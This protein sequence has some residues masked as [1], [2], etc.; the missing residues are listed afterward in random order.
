MSI[1][2]INRL[3]IYDGFDAQTEITPHSGLY[4]KYAKGIYEFSSGNIHDYL[5]QGQALSL[6][7]IGTPSPRFSGFKAVLTVFKGMKH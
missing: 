4:G 1:S 3:H 7:F 6:Y 5:S 2:F